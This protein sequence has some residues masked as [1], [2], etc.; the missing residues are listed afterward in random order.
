MTKTDALPLSNSHSQACTWTQTDSKWAEGYTRTSPSALDGKPGRKE[1]WVN[2]ACLICRWSLDA[3]VG[4]LAL[5]RVIWLSQLSLALSFSLSLSFQLGYIVIHTHMHTHSHSLCLSDTDSLLRA[6][7]RG[8]KLTLS[9]LLLNG[10]MQ[11]RADRAVIP[12]EPS[13]ARVRRR[14]QVRRVN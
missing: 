11:P 9:A 12:L 13:A 8:L 5:R 14:R 10:G 1:R 4:S 7:E 3:E 6:L 2:K